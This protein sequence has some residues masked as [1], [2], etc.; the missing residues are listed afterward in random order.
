MFHPVKEIFKSSFPLF[1]PSGM[2]EMHAQRV[3]T[4]QL[5]AN[6]EELQRA[7]TA[8]SALLQDLEDKSGRL[9]VLKSTASKQQQVIKHLEGLLKRTVGELR[10]HKDSSREAARLTTELSRLR[11]V[12]LAR[13][14]LC[15]HHV[16]W[17]C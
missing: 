3:D 5:A 16:T 1:T 7:H 2:Q 13:Q 4:M 6:M 10:T 17:P 11:E 14:N 15:R 8:Q 12:R 9:P